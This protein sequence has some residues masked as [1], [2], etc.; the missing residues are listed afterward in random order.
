[1][2]KFVKCHGPKAFVYRYYWR[3]NNPPILY[4]MTNKENLRRL[5]MQTYSLQISN[6]ALLIIENYSH[7]QLFNLHMVEIVKK[8]ELRFQI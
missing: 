6:D 7:V 4:T 5:D 1:M 8:L 2:Q 3:R